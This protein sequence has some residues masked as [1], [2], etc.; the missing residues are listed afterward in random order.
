MNKRTNE[1]F[2]DQEDTTTLWKLIFVSLFNY[3]MLS[4][5]KRKP[6][7][8]LQRHQKRNGKKDKL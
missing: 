7:K 6:R 4:K 1:H 2:D 5:I 8:A 3:M